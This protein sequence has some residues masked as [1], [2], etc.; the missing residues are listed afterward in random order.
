MLQQ[1]LC[2]AV[3]GGSG[4]QENGAARRDLLGDQSGYRA[5]ALVAAGE[6]LVERIVHFLREWVLGSQPGSSEDPHDQA[7]S[8]QFVEVPAHGGGRGL[9]GLG[10]SGGAGHLVFAQLLQEGALTSLFDH[11]TNLQATSASCNKFDHQ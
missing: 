5:F 6:H 2:Y 3:G 10:Q 1:F 4:L 9:E 8:A 11:D 7:Q